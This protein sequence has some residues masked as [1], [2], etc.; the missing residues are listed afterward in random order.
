[1][2]YL[3]TLT[4]SLSLCHCCLFEMGPHYVAQSGL[5]LA[6]PLCHLMSEALGSQIGATLPDYLSD[7][8]TKSLSHSVFFCF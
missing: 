8:I 3:V 5:E 6:V 7:P 1:M 4:L 2:Y